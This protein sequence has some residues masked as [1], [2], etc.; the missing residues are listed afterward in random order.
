MASGR[1]PNAEWGYNLYFRFKICG[2]ISKPSLSVVIL[3]SSYPRKPNVLVISINHGK[4]SCKKLTRLRTSS[5]AAL[6]MIC[7]RSF[8]PTCW[9]SLK[10]AK[11]PS[12]AISR[13]NV[14]Y[15]RDFSSFRIR[16]FSRFSVKL[17]IRTQ[18]NPTCFHSSIMSTGCSLM[19]K[20][21]IR[22][23]Q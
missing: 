3:P 17:Q 7:S 4:K 21:T 23:C 15:F 8:C 10:F 11:S 6:E 14:F 9:N 18:F 16:H 13:Q 12:L 1:R 19:P 5:N 2:Y 22:S 20:S